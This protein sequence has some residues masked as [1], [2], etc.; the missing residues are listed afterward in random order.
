VLTRRNFA[1]VAS[2]AI[3][4]LAGFIASDASAQSPQPA[5]SGGG[6]TRRKILAQVDGPIP[7]YTTIVMDVIL[8]PG[9]T[10]AR[11]THPGIESTYVLE[12]GGFDLLIEGQPARTVKAGDA[13]QIPPGTPHGGGKTGVA[14]TRLLINYIVERDKPLVNPA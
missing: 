11:H 4:G 8:E 3:C 10:L 5:P 7:G 13:I 2:C 9:E 14:K 6:G 12:G 1:E